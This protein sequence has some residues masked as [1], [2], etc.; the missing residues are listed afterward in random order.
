MSEKRSTVVVGEDTAYICVVVLWIP[1]INMCLDHKE[2]LR[3]D[4]DTYFTRIEPLVDKH[5][6][7]RRQ[8]EVA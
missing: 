4:V 8:S 5:S 3:L 6:C 2:E 1:E 7:G